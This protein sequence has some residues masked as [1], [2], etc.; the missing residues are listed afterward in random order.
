MTYR[1]FHRSPWLIWL[2]LVAVT[3][4]SYLVG[5]FTGTVD[6][7]LTGLCVLWFALLKVLCVMSEFMEM[8]GAA[9]WLRRL[10]VAWLGGLGALMSVS[11]LT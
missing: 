4:L 10:G 3:G 6:T 5:H 2:L 9:P 8:R 1:E 7:R 11:Y